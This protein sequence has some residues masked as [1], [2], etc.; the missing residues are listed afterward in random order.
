MLVVDKGDLRWPN[1]NPYSPPVGQAP[2][3]PVVEVVKTETVKKIKTHKTTQI[4]LS[5]EAQKDSFVSSAR[6]GE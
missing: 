4:V 2:P 6:T 1:P 5:P 3:A